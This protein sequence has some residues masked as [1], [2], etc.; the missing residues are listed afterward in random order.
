M[1]AIFN[2]HNWA[3]EN[4]EAFPNHSK[5]SHD[6]GRKNVSF[7]HIDQIPSQGIPCLE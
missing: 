2:V 7:P 1:H 3:F 4:H 5:G 6:I